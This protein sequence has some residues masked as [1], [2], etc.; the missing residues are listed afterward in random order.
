MIICKISLYEG[1]K[2]FSGFG[3]VQSSRKRKQVDEI[4]TN[5][6]GKKLNPSPL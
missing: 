3:K 1:N 5:K 4:D 2:L 6:N